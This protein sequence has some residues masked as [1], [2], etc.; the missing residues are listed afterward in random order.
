[1]IL[2]LVHGVRGN[3]CP[4]WVNR[5]T[6][7]ALQSLPV[8]PDERTFSLPW[9]VSKVPIPEESFLDRDSNCC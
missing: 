7:T 5:V 1:M 8:C 3:Q 9:R 4:I 6:L 2:T